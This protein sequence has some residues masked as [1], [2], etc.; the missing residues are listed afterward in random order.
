MTVLHVCLPVCGWVCI[1]VN[2][3]GHVR[4]RKIGKGNENVAVQ[5]SV[6][7]LLKMREVFHLRASVA[8]FLLDC[9]QLP[10]K[11]TETYYLSVLNLILCLPHWLL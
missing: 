10:Y 6:R 8:G 4:E 2:V 11:A 3:L 7:D 1:S 5:F 9:Y